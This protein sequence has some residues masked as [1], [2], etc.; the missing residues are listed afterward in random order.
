MKNIVKNEYIHF[1]VTKD[2]KE[3]ILKRSADLNKKDISDYIRSLVEKDILSVDMNDTE[4]PR[5]KE[6][7][8]MVADEFNK[9]NDKQF[10]KTNDMIESKINFIESLAFWSHRQHLY[11]FFILAMRLKATGN[12]QKDDLKK[13]DE[14]AI[15][16][17]NSSFSKY[18]DVTLSND[19]ES[20]LNY[21]KK[22]M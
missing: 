2:F 22:P 16:N 20:I 21:L 9:N 14:E 18:L 15:K 10:N 1:K 11:S 19:S 12:L 17:V 7:A 8:Q 6:F 4:K 13:I 3:K 5:M